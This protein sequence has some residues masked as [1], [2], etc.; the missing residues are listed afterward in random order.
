MR[1]EWVSSRVRNDSSN[2]TPYLSHSPLHFPSHFCMIPPSYSS[3]NESTKTR[4][5]SQVFSFPL[6]LFVQVSMK[7]P[8]V[9]PSSKDKGLISYNFYYLYNNFL[10]VI[11]KSIRRVRL[12]CQLRKL[13]TSFNFNP[14][15]LNS[16]KPHK[17]G[18]CGSNQRRVNKVQK[19]KHWNWKVLTLASWWLYRVYARD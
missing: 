18:E 13:Q 5:K 10:K 12:K 9:N 16:T 19:L 14:P 4:R 11:V 17:K 15:Q 3:L 1:C 6:V 7:F 2:R 8:A